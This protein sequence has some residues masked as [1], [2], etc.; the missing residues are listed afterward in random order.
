MLAVKHDFTSKII[1]ILELHFGDYAQQLLENS[2][3]LQYLNI[4]TK[5]A[6]RASKSRASFAN[7]YAIYVLVEDYIN[8]GFHKND[9]YDEYAGAQFTALFKR[10][11]E[12]PFGSKL[13]NHALNH[14]LNEEFRKY[15]LISSH[16]PVIRDIETN[17]Y[18][19]NENLLK[20]SYDR[21]QFNIAVAVKEII[22]AYIETRRCAF[23]TFI[24][25]C[26]QIMEIQDQEPDKAVGF[27]RN[28][29]RPNADARIF[30]IVSYAILK[31]FYSDQL[32][33]WGWS[34]DVINAEHLILYKTGR[35][36]AN[37]WNRFRDE[38]AW[39]VFSSD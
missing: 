17:R 39:K 7:H 18:W 19:I 32:I 27:I 33:Y 34:L 38:T 26:Q 4:K 20:L 16:L 5:A 28:L 10:Q 37:D 12:L 8:N 6:H 36:N 29:L 31:H 24:A 9:S 23:V 15:F 3:L 30:E 11:R 35:T 2:E 14:R 21:K 1:E 13:Q 25:D 22:E